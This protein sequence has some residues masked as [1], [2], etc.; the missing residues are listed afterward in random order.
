M[1]AVTEPHTLAQPPAAQGARPLQ[2]DIESYPSSSLP[3]ADRKPAPALVTSNPT[4]D[5][6]SH[7]LVA[8]LGDAATAAP[9]DPT[10]AAYVIVPETTA[11]HSTL[12]TAQNLPDDPFFG[13][14]G[15]LAANNPIDF[16]EMTIGARTAG[17]RF[18]LAA[19]Q[20]SATTPL[21]F[22][23]Y[24]ATGRVL[25]TW[26]AGASSQGDVSSVSLDFAGRS[27]SAAL[28]LA[29]SAPPSGG[30]GPVSALPSASYQLWVT[31]LSKPDGAST[32]GGNDEAAASTGPTASLIL[33]PLQASTTAPLGQPAHAGAA[34]SATTGAGAGAGPAVALAALPTRAAGLLGGVLASRD[35]NRPAL[36]Q[37]SVTVNLEASERASQPFDRDLAAVDRP[38]AEPGPGDDARELEAIRGPRGFPLLGATAIGNWR[39]TARRAAATS[40]VEL[41]LAAMADEE[42]EA[43]AAGQQAVAGA[44]APALA[45]AAPDALIATDA[46]T[47]MPRLSLWGQTRVTLSFGLSMA[48]FLTL[49]ALLSDPVAG[50]D[51]LATCLD[52]EESEAAALKA[53]QVRRACANQRGNR[54]GRAGR[55]AADAS[56]IRT[57][58]L[59]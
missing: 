28:Y 27:P 36:R 43:L 21:Q 59:G 53:A 13:V 49:N 15:T 11:P 32:S 19:Q 48:T 56:V 22:A 25:G 58:S 7:Y 1:S 31:R 16:F 46:A 2:A 10:H 37:L 24:D 6:D 35:E 23:L 30:N 51:Y 33:G 50:F 39:R 3:E 34:P 17:L 12:A 44:T 18:E 40:A 14:I 5:D 52:S 8:T 57:R 45:V 29:I 41:A 4:P 47:T 42:I 54:S 26:I 9:L 55:Q 20:P 38:Q